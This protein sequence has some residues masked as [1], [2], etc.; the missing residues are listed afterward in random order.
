[1]QPV[2]ILGAGIN[3]AAVARDLAINGVPVLI[4][5]SGD[6][7]QGAT[8]RS[9]RLIHGGLRYLEYRDLRLV[10]ES[11]AERERLLKTAPQFVR[12]IC[13][14]IPVSRAIGGLTSAA[15]RF[16]GL[17]ATQFGQSLLRRCHSPRGLIAVRFGLWLY[18]LLARGSS[19]PRHSVQ[20]SGGGK[21]GWQC[22][23]WDAQLE[24]PERF[25]LSMLHDAQAAAEELGIEFRVLTRHRLRISRGNVAIEPIAPQANV[26]AQSSTVDDRPITL[27]PSLVINATGAWGDATL[28]SLG[29]KQPP[30]FAGTRGSHLF[31]THAP[32]RHLV[33]D[34]G[35]Y[36]EA[37]DGRLVF[38]LPLGRGVLIGT[39]DL[40]HAGSPGDAVATD[41]E[42]TYL[43]DMVNSVL[44]EADLRHEHVEVRHAGVR[45]LPRTPDRSAAA[46]PRGHTVS[47]SDSD[48]VPIATLIGGKLTTCR[49]LAEEVS[50]AVF[51]RQGL[52]RQHSTIDRPLPG[53]PANRTGE[54]R[55]IAPNTSFGTGVDEPDHRE[56]TAEQA[57]TI[58]RLVGERLDEIC[59]AKDFKPANGT[60]NLTGT[61]IPRGFVRWSIRREWVT[62]LNDLVERRLMLVF[63]PELQQATL[64]ELA[65]L[66]VAEGRLAQPDRDAEIERSISLLERFQGKRV[67]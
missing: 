20:H 28:Q 7:A 37:G 10:R 24:F 41:D 1:M 21:R 42:V 47:W 35:I 29:V 67:V 25:V 56:I 46:V 59:F 51:R 38:I 60:D 22:A 64:E 30:L 31:T 40:P 2:V 15:I 34:G 57:Q 33:D 61:T 3:G 8:S 19:L 32:L 12:P 43:L 49:Q 48:G 16:S 53:H 9:S 17:S 13:L 27:R 36:A 65:D 23:Y 39:T 52:L 66:L 14:H 5:E 62:Q 45:P 44:P 58:R 4:V 26:L 55:P 6:V 18:D 11:L 63:E 50:D 54:S